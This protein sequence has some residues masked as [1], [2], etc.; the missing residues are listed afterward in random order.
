MMKGSVYYIGVILRCHCLVECVGTENTLDA[1]QKQER[2]SK[3]HERWSMANEVS[4]A[5]GILLVLALACVGLPRT[6]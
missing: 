4:Q 5:A 3:R 6:T 1:E 2:I